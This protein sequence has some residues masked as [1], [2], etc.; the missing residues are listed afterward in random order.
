M[1][2]RGGLVGAVGAALSFPGEKY[3]GT[4][5]EGAGQQCPSA[6]STSSVAL[7]PKWKGHPLPQARASA[8]EHSDSSPRAVTLWAELVLACFFEMSEMSSLWL[9]GWYSG[10]KVLGM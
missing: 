10:D 6:D 8:S 4:S 9:C 3:S 1:T 7:C 2:G 5:S